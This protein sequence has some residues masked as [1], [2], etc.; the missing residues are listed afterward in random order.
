ME[1]KKT[2]KN[3]FLFGKKNYVIINNLILKYHGKKEWFNEVN[4][5]NQQKLKINAYL[6]CIYI[7]TVYNT[8]DEV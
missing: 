5:K 6:S 8:V 3:T 2:P 7:K 4:K 1:N